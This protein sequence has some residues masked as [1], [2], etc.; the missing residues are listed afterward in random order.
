MYVC[1][2]RLASRPRSKR[3]TR[4]TILATPG[5]RA[6]NRWLETLGF[7]T[8]KQWYVEIALDVVDRPASS[9]YHNEIDT[10]FH[11]NLY[12]EEWGVFFCHGSRASWIRVTDE[13]FVHGR[14]DHRLLREISE[15][16]GIGDLLRE[17]ERRHRIE[18][19]RDRAL[20]HTNVSGA[21]TALREWLSNL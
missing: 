14:D 15:L 1:P 2:N 7:A 4:R 20:I 3:Q 12:P 9:T 17:L 13:P 8:E 19:R 10:R 21:K 6:A 5:A 11:L 16:A 18:F